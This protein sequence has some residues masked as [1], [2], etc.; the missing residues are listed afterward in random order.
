MKSLNF[1]RFVFV[2]VAFSVF[3][4]SCGDDT[5]IIDTAQ[6]P[7]LDFLDSNSTI[8]A[9]ATIGAGEN[10][11]VSL[12]GTKTDNKLK[13]ITV[14]ED[15]INISID[16]LSLNANPTLLAGSQVD[17]FDALSIT[18]KTHTNI[19]AKI[20]S[21]ILEDINGKKVTKSLVI[22]SVSVDPG[23][24]IVTS[25]DVVYSDTLLKP[26][27][28]FTVQLKGI[29]TINDLRTITVQENGINISLD[30]L[31]LNAN[32]TLLTGANVNGFNEFLIAIRTHSDVSTKTYSFI[33]EDVKGNKVSK[34]ILISTFTK[35]DVLMG[36][37][38]NQGG[39]VGTGGLDLD[40]GVST[41]SMDA[42]AEL[43]DEGIDLGAPVASN[44]FQQISGV[45]NTEVKYIKKGSNGVSENFSF[46]AIKYKEEI[47]GLWGNGTP[48]TAKIGTRDV[49]NKVAKDDIFIAKKGN[50]YYLLNVVNVKVTTNDN[51]DSY[52]FDIKK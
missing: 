22:T 12:K 3:F 28:D 26:S 37:L 13:T 7:K 17:G 10:F 31:S 49:S 32:P 44:W 46:D 8:S 6:D 14:Q 41:G 1:F 27:E 52:E 15:G 11:T 42:S 2:F 29:K 20:Y 16:R 51:A 25:N 34:S 38:L 24:E 43:R 47:A 18:I 5:N 39:P 30:R 35:A 21:F 33:L 9:D 4:T 19:S 40:N 23:L 48:F 36:V 45:N 50:N